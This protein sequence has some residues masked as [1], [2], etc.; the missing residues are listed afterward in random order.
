VTPCSDVVGYQCFGGAYCLPLY[1]TA[2]QH[3][4]PRIE[5]YMHSL[6]TPTHPSHMSSPSYW[7]HCPNNTKWSGYTEILL[8]FI[9]LPN[10]FLFL[11]TF[12]NV[13]F[14]S[15]HFSN[16]F[17]FLITLPNVFLFLSLFLMFSCFLSR[18]VMFSCLLSLFLM[19][20]CFL[21]LFLMFSCLLSLF[22]LRHEM[23]RYDQQVLYQK[24][25]EVS[26]AVMLWVCIRGV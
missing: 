23:T 26:I 9:T 16:A 22:V 4:R 5:F 8:V 2:S 24:H 17:L 15:C 7:L 14:V 21:S 13:F 19:F 20:S 3:R 1:C 12:P 11:V 10:V 6:F 18:F 25:G